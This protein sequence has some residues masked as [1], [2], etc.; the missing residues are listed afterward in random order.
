MD[1]GRRGAG[2]NR[3]PCLFSLSG[4]PRR[5]SR[6]RYLWRLN[7][8]TAGRSNC[9]GLGLGL[10]YLVLAIDG[11]AVAFA[12]GGMLAYWL[13]TPPSFNGLAARPELWPVLVCA[14][15]GNTMIL[16]WKHR[17]DLSQPPALRTW[18]SR[19]LLV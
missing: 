11:W 17:R 12:L 4:L 15:L 7:R 1:P 3:R 10:G 2:A 18:L 16:L 9:L 19:R 8:L 5:Q 13:L 14:W 6:G